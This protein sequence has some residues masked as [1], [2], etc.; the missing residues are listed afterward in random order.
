M[1]LQSII[2]KL[3]T[4][5][6]QSYLQCRRGYY[7]RTAF[8]VPHARCYDSAVNPSFRGNTEQVRPGISVS[9]SDALEQ[10]GNI[11]ARGKGRARPGTDESLGG[12]ESGISAL[13]RKT[14]RDRE[15]PNLLAVSGSE[16]EISV[17][18]CKTERDRESPNL[19]MVSGSEPGISVLECKTERD[20]ESPCL[21]IGNLR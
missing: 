7:T 14:E 20:R 15:S 10:A 9:H 18:E 5:Y 3:F 4:S 1:Y 17:L 21:G 13:E 16:P 6:L 12:S 2:T 19:L 8:G 11:R